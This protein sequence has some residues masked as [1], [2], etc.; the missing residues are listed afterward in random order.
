MQA[1]E[2]KY[3]GP[4]NHRGA[5]IKASCHAGQVT[6]SRDCA[7]NIDDNHRAAARALITKLGWFGS[8]VSGEIASLPNSQVHV[9]VKRE[10]GTYQQWDVW[11]N[12]QK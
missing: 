12:E 2:T 3:L 8:W 7:M 6:I 9:N 10:G 4:T 1:I 5:R 11:T